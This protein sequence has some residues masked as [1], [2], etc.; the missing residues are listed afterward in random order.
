MRFFDWLNGNSGAIQGI[1]AIIALAFTA[2]LIWVTWRYTRLTKRIADV[3]AS[4]LAAS[5][6]P[7]I[8]IAVDNKKIGYNKEGNALVS[9]N[10]KVTNNGTTPIKL[11]RVTAFAIFGPGDMSEYTLCKDEMMVLMP[12][13]YFNGP[14]PIEVGKLEDRG[15]ERKQGVVAWC[16]DLSG[17]SKHSFVYHADAQILRHIFGFEA[18]SRI[19]EVED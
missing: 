17:L 9:F 8:A 5:L 4:Q 1:A 16:T 3:T 18:P 2:A 12:K 6:A 11:C 10:V 15:N 7:I 13:E 19:T 14:A